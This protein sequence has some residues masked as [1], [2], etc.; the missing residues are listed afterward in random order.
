MLL[1]RNEKLR[2]AVRIAV[3]FFI[4][5]TI[6]ILGA[7]VFDGKRHILIALAVAV[8]SLVLFAAGFEKKSTGTRRMVIVAVMTALCFAGRFIPFLKPVAALTIITGLYLGG[9]AG[10]LVGSLSAV[11]SNFYFGQ[12]PWTAF[13]M[14]AWGLI[15]LFAGIFSEKLLKSRVLLLLY[16]ATTGI[17]YSFIMDIWTVLWYDQGFSLKLYLAAL[18]SAVPY[19]ASYAVSNVLFLYLLAKPFG[20]KLDRIKTKYGV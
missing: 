19:T 4:I 18:A 3:P 7:L 11:L 13:Q 16:G 5:P 6:T 20:E 9:E 12:G 2:N 15:G 17:A 10:F 1:I 8:L 14:L